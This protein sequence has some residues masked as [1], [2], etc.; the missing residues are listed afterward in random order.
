[1]QRKLVLGCLAAALT[2]VPLAASAQ[3]RAYMLD[4]APIYS[5]PGSEYPVVA[6]L[7][8]GV[9]VT[10]Q[11]C[12]NDYSWCD[13]T[14][15]GNR[16]WVYAGELG[17]PYR[18]QRVP[19][20]D[21]GPQLS[22]PIITFSLGNY[23]DRHYRSR[24]WYHERNDWDR[25]WRDGGWRNEHRYDGRGRNDWR[26]RDHD[27]GNRGDRG[28]RG[29]RGNRNGQRDNNDR[30]SDGSYNNG[31]NNPRN[32]GNAGYTLQPGRDPQREWERAMG[33]TSSRQQ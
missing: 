16:G 4:G 23:W 13:V 6:Q 10:V 28:D 11:G 8:P 26:D 33:D 3:Q 19:I 25:R 21:Y 5:G 30:R 2:A 12:L 17:Y 29:D 15:G 7:G 27:R 31:R 9:G 18:N 22:L 14:F 20:I 24:P 32:E 1:M